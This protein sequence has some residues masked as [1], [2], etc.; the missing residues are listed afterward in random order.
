[1]WKADAKV[2]LSAHGDIVVNDSPDTIVAKAKSYG[3]ADAKVNM[4]SYDGNIKV[5]NSTIKADA[6]AGDDNI[7]NAKINM[8]AY[9]DIDIE[10]APDTVLAKAD[11]SLSAYAKVNMT[12]E[13]GNIKVIN[14]TVKAVSEADYS[15]EATVNML[16]YYDIL[17]K[18]ATETIEANAYSEK[19]AAIAKVDMDALSG[20]IKVKNS[21]VKADAWSH[22]GDAEAKVNMYAQYDIDIVDAPDTVSAN[23]YGHD[24]ADAKVNMTSELGNIKVKNSKI[25]ADA[26]SATKIGEAK[27]EMD[28]NSDIDIVDAAVSANV[29]GYEVADA[30]V[31]M[32]SSY[33]SIRVKNSTVKADA[34]AY[35]DSEAKVNM[36]AYNGI[37]I[38]DSPDSIIAEAYSHAGPAVA[39]VTM[40]NVY[41]NIEVVKSRVKATAESYLSSAEAKVKMTAMD[42][43]ILVKNSTVKAESD[44]F[45]NSEAKVDMYALQNITVVDS[46][47]T[48]IADAYSA[49]TTAKAIVNM[50]SL[51]GGIEIKNSTVK[52][53]AETGGSYKAEAKINM[54]AL[55]DIVV[56]DSP[57][58]IVAK[59]KSYGETDAKVNMS[60]YDGNIK[61]KNSTIKADANSKNDQAEAQVNM[62]AHKDIDIV[63]APD[64]VSAKAEGL[65]SADAKVNMTSEEG[66]IKV[67]NSKVKAESDSMDFSEAKVNMN[68]QGG[69]IKIINSTVK[70]VSVADYVSKAVVN[71]IADKNILVE[72]AAETVEANASS[73][74]STAK[75]KGRHASGQGHYCIEIDHQ[76]S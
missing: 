49:D 23:V 24:G 36:E 41:N 10:D 76:S 37:T 13:Q 3:E 33:G 27:V 70:A 20:S 28:A 50:D 54:S 30:K 35:L 62:F 47:D 21:T 72:D 48:I 31:K 75:A 66:D 16:A 4:S 22:G 39:A 17:V 29:F 46:P 61:V 67:K 7:A 11:G 58:T 15:S 63:D 55:N 71:M 43:D 69:N 42:A 64:T 57:D 60:S 73:K 12:S 38:V 59:A 2:N 14:S 34:N 1:M 19:L 5:K 26:N 40:H 56:A 18:D 52:A 74:N 53:N 44:A 45:T 65:H 8:Y 51:I 68:A 6:S 9:G 32:D 25:K